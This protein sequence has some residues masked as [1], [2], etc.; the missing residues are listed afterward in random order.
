MRTGS[1][2][3]VSEAFD[4]QP[5]LTGTNVC[6]RPIRTDEFEA[7][8]AVAADPLMWGQHPAKDRS[9]RVV[10]EKW[11]ADAVPQ[12]ALTIEELASQRVIGSSRYYDWNPATREVAIG[13]TFIARDH[14]GGATNAEVKRLMLD[15]AF[16]SARTVWFH[17]DPANTRSRKAMEKIGGIYTHIAMISIAGAA[18]RDYA[19]YRIDAP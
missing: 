8:Y 3:D 18:A 16:E 12:L 4:F 13:F 17:V 10:F 7:L 14:W 19:F 1:R 9:Q 2:F 15:H 5:V 6:V 11:F